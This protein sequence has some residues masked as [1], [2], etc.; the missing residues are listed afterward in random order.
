MSKPDAAVI[1]QYEALTDGAGLVELPGRTL[2]EVQG[3]DRATFLHNLCTCD[4]KKLQPGQG[5]EAFFTDASGKILGFVLLFVEAESIILETMPDQAKFFLTHLDRYIFREDV[6]LVDR[7]SELAEM[8]LA[9]RKS[10]ALLAEV[11]GVIP[12]TER[13]THMP[14]EIGGCQ[15]ILRRVD[16]TEQGGYLIQSSAEDATKISKVLTDAGAVPCSSEVFE[17]ARVEAGTPQFGQDISHDNLP[18]EI[19]RDALAISFTKGCYIGQETVARIDALGHVNRK[20]RGIRF[21]GDDVP[22]AGTELTA[23]DKKAGQVT[24]SVYSLKLQS[25]LALGFVRRGLEQAGQQ[26]ESPAG[27]AEVLVLPA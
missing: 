16:W 20:L 12:P 26:L 4:V 17:I 6:Q 9:G 14:T 19:D 24:S 10:G 15:V 8:L 5:G 18:Q 1:Q 25:P 7:T 22:P 13:L 23:T 27:T 11:A 2:V 3:R 21:S